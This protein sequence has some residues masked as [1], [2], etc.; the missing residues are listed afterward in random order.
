VANTWH[1]SSLS[2]S[3]AAAAA[4]DNWSAGKILGIIARTELTLRKCRHRHAFTPMPMQVH[5]ACGSKHS[6]S[7]P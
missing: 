4:G 1:Q 7:A 6:C 5:A 3:S 2:L